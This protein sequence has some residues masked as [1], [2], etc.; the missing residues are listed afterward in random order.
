MLKHSQTS[1]LPHLVKALRF[2]LRCQVWSFRAA[3]HAF[4]PPL[5]PDTSVQMVKE[6]T[7]GG[8]ESVTFEESLG[9]A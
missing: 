2:S 8:G 7:E 1:Y 6:I 3:V 5:F 4:I 9:D